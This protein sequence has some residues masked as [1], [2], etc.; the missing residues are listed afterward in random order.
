[1]TAE[2]K[3][4]LAWGAW[5]AA[6]VVA[7][8]IALRSGHPQAPMT[9]HMRHTLGVRR[10]PAHRALG[11]LAYGAGIGWLALHLWKE[12]KDVPTTA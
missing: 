9:Y 4:R 10:G 1:M 3:W 2:H 5:V 11:Q 12:I 7:E 8:T 6:F